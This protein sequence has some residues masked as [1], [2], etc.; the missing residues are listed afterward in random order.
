MATMVTVGGEKKHYLPCVVLRLKLYVH[1]H[2]TFLVVFLKGS[3]AT[4]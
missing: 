2:Q 3:I 4:A 1:H